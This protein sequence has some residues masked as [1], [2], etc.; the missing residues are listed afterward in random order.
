MHTT[1]TP[2]Y[3]PI[4][5]LLA[6][7]SSLD[8]EMKYFTPFILVLL[9]ICIIGAFGMFYVYYFWFFNFLL[10]FL[11]IS[12]APPVSPHPHTPPCHIYNHHHHH[13]NTAPCTHPSIRSFIYTPQPQGAD[14]E[15]KTLGEWSSPIRLAGN[16][17][18]P[19]NYYF[20]IPS[21]F[22][23]AEIVV[24]MRELSDQSEQGF[25]PDVFVKL[26]A[27]AN[28][29]SND[30]SDTSDS[31]E[32][33]VVLSANRHTWA[34]GDKVYIGLLA[35]RSASGVVQIMAETHGCGSLNCGGAGEE[36]G[37]C[38]V[39]GE[40]PV[41]VCKPK[42]NLHPECA[43]ESK[44]L[45]LDNVPVTDSLLGSQIMYYNVNA[46]PAS[47]KGWL[48]VT[49]D[50]KSRSN[51]S[52]QVAIRKGGLPSEDIY[53][54]SDT[55]YSVHS[56]LVITV[57]STLYSQGQW[58][59]GVLNGMGPVEYEI[60]AK[61]FFC[62][63]DC[64]G[65]GTC[66]NATST[67]TCQA[68][69]TLRP[70]CSVMSAELHVNERQVI[71]MD[72]W[73]EKFFTI[74]VSQK[75]ADA[76]LELGIHMTALN[77]TTKTGYGNWPTMF[78]NYE[79]T[80]APTAYKYDAISPQP[81][82]WNQTFYLADTKIVPGQ[83][84][85]MMRNGNADVDYLI[86]LESRVHCPPGCSEHGVCNML[87]GCDC[88]PGYIGGSCQ[89]SREKCDSILD[90]VHG[91][92]GAWVFFL[93]MLFLALSAGISAFVYAKFF[94]VEKNTAPPAELQYDP[95]QVN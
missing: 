72:P 1:I 69:Y 48:Q 74:P 53:D 91:T 64:S 40:T 87:G 31:Y 8:N 85:V 23:Q 58:V 90:I 9:L 43:A 30:G 46:P 36:R 3:D 60:S 50:R 12:L 68:G 71:H 84:H 15:I 49:V 81:A 61:A 13:I 34:A 62:S 55:L 93:F 37:M 35:W 5:A 66:N 39:S 14:V 75:L 42:F 28:R 86:N 51:G 19:D 16:E 76:P 78:L 7:H 6:V 38:D 4:I 44:D 70:D 65:H 25:D 32:H 18:A 29:T 94:Y 92:R 33:T 73:E 56:S 11:C 88:F 79:G 27:P 21:E 95:L 10:G 26:R 63:H 59:I 83:M 17:Y 47:T 80:V 57:P 24:R 22:P 77:E 20:V 41:C 2:Y 67:C 82:Q 52:V 89:I 54:A 45:A